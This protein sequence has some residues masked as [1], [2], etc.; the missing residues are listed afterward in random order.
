MDLPH[1]CP[2]HALTIEE[3]GLSRGLVV[4]LVLKHV[5]LEGATTVRQVMAATKL[6]YG[7]VLGAYRYLQ[8]EQLSEPRGTS[9]DDIEFGLTA[10]GLRRAEEAY[11]KNSYAGPAPV[12]L[13]SYG[14]AVRSQALQPQ[15][16]Q[17][18]ITQSLLDLVVPEETIRDLGAALMTGGAVFLYGPTGNGKTSVAERL[19]RIFHD[20]VYIPFAV[21]VSNQILMVYDPNVH[22]LWWQQ[23]EEADPRWALCYQIGR[24]HV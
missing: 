1:F 13:A 21:E 22:R 17:E 18:S 20:L 6:D 2:S 24:A 19:H 3:T 5:F 4:D 12:P 9:G 23:P 15:V 16:T 8:K 11:R 7:V 14:Q 10:K